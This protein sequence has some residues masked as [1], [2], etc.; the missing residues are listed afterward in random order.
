VQREE[1]MKKWGKKQNGAQQTTRET[2]KGKQ[3]TNERKKEQTT[4]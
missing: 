1:K 2:T 4:Q 3:C